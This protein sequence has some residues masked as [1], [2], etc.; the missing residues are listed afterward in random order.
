MVN[1]ADFRIG[2]VDIS[3]AFLQ[4]SYL[5]KSERIIAILPP[6]IRVDQ[7]KSDNE[8]VDKGRV[9]V[10]TTHKASTFGD[11]N[12]KSSGAWGCRFEMAARR[13]IVQTTLR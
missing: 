6:Y 5:R 13:Q 7:T 11:D 1:N 12:R 2:L 4:S 3:Q 10:A 8:R 9:L